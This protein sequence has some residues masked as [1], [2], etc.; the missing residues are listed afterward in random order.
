VRYL[1]LISG[2]SRGLGAALAEHAIAQGHAVLTFAR[3]PCAH[4][5]W[6]P[7]DLADPIKAEQSFAAALARRGAESFDGY[8]LVNNAAT[9]EPI[10]TAYGA[11]QAQA[12]LAVNLV[13]PIALSRVFLR[14]LAERDAAKRIV[15]VSSGAAQRAFAGW[16]LYCAAKAGL[17]HFGRCVALEQAQARFPVDVVNL[18]PG[19][20]DTAMQARI[21]AA[22]ADEFPS[23]ARFIDL[24]R[25]GQLASPAAVARK[26]LAG[27]VGRRRYAGAT[28]AIDEFVG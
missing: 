6:V 14:E 23:V 21:R 11:A 2:A 9:I 25:S 15:N 3:S 16:S 22:S 10:G 5:E 20:I 18:S 26:L 7:L 19:V 24:A 27:I 8:A 12:H 1:L 4:G 13:A 28:V 17:D